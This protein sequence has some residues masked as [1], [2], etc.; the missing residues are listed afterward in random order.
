M[1]RLDRTRVSQLIDLNAAERTLTG[2]ERTIR[3]EQVA[4]LIKAAFDEASDQARTDF[5]ARMKSFPVTAWPWSAVQTLPPPTPKPVGGGFS[6]QAKKFG[7]PD[8]V[9]A[10]MILLYGQVTAADQSPGN[11]LPTRGTTEAFLYEPLFAALD[12]W[13][14]TTIKRWIGP[15]SWS[16]GTGS[17]QPG[18]EQPAGEP[19]GSTSG[20]PADGS[21]LPATTN[22]P[23]WRSRPVLIGT[24][25]VVTT[26][27]TLLSIRALLQASRT[28]S[29]LEER[30]RASEGRA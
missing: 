11:D 16:S 30:L 6:L 14:T 22:V 10:L 1:T 25:V 21:A 28:S 19:E 4:I 9:P 27:L 24:G 17:Q 15:Q 5:M 26:T 8:R 13:D 12:A 18:T 7:G 23:I 20:P 3:E 2:V 29:R